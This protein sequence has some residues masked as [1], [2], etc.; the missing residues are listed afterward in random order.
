MLLALVVGRV[1]ISPVNSNRNN[2]ST[3]LRITKNTIFFFI[4]FF[5]FIFRG[6]AGPV[7]NFS[8]ASLALAFR[9][10]N[11][12][13]EVAATMEEMLDVVEVCMDEYMDICMYRSVRSFC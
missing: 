4:V 6:M 2:I 11:V 9:T 13:N 8:S 1:F 5:F 7:A 3:I 10:L 12:R